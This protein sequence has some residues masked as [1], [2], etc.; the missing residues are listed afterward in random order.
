MAARQEDWE[1]YRRQ[2][3]IT[4]EL[5]KCCQ[6]D[7][8]LRLAR[9]FKVNPEMLHNFVGSK[10]KVI[11]KIGPLK[12]PCGEICC[13]SKKKAELLSDQFKPVFIRET[14]LYSRNREK[15]SKYF[16]HFNK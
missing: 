16:R 3:N 14:K 5:I 9:N 15:N 8:E 1:A 6:R 4:A 7:K 11:E 12:N 2:R 13:N 10:M